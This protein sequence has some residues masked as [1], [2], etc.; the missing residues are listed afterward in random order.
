VYSDLSA[1]EEEEAKEEAAKDQMFTCCDF[2]FDFGTNSYSP[3]DLD[4]ACM[5]PQSK[6]SRFIN[7]KRC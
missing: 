2:D 3:T 4:L 7:P 6:L 5:H 1:D